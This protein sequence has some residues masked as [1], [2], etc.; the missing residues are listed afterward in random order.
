MIGTFLA[1]HHWHKRM[2]LLSP[3][4]KFSNWMIF[5]NK[6]KDGFMFAFCISVHIYQFCISFQCFIS[7]KYFHICPVWLRKLL[8]SNFVHYVIRH[9]HFGVKGVAMGKRCDY[10]VPKLLVPLDEKMITALKG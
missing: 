4:I 6:N 10:V 9:D 7:K 8:E 1:K 2:C 3:L 5:L